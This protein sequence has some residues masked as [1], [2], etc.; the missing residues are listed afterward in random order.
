MLN[1]Q[2]QVVNKLN[3]PKASSINREYSSISLYY[4]LVALMLCKQSLQQVFCFWY[5]FKRNVMPQSYMSRQLWRSL[6][7]LR[8][9]D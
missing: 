1:V 7:H 4:C 6:A 9:K 5:S 2:N 3:L 8:K